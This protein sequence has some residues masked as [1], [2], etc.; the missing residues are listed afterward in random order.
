[1]LLLTVATLLMS[2]WSAFGQR[3][4][5]ARLARMRASPRWHDGAFVNPQAM[6]NDFRGAMTGTFDTSDDASP[7]GAVAVV[8][9][10]ARAFAKAPASGL[11]VTW[12]GHSSTLIEIDGIRVLTDPIWSERAS[13]VGWAGPTRWYSPPIA[14]E[15]L[16][17]IDAVV[18]SHDH[19]DHLDRATI[20]AMRSW[21]NL[22]I[23][24]LGIGAHLASWGIPDARVVEL[25]WWES[26]IVGGVQIVATP[27]RHASGRMLP[28]SDRTLWAGYAMLGATHH[29]F[30]SGDTGL[31]DTLEDIGRKLGPFDVT[32]IESGQYDAA[33][34]D[35]HLGPEQAVE[36]NRLVRGRVMIPVH[37]G[38]FQLAFHSWTEPVERVLAAG[39]CQGVDVLTPRPG[40]SVE[41]TVVPRTSVVPWWPQL[42][43]K[44]AAQAPVVATRN[45]VSTDRVTPA[46]CVVR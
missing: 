2:A 23:V 11:R 31:H 17:P 24:P 28:Q 18:I 13:P 43:W 14:L 25:D 40:E 3:A 9:P 12:F 29:A 46:G 35:W 15:S 21:S 22:F 36:A 44:T 20:M 1:M 37:W 45:G 34:P 42:P 10:S 16:P 39:R 7:S 4:D 32:L 26:K 19:F 8:R 33:W 5:G 6:W 41:P 30:Y 38:L 27:S